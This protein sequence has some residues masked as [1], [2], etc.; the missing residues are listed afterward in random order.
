MDTLHQ[1]NA[2]HAKQSADCTKTETLALRG[3][4]EG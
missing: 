4:S 2:E 3:R 1:M